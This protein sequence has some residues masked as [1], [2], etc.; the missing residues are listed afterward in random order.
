MF[1][2]AVRKKSN[3]LEKFLLKTG[4]TNFCHSQFLPEAWN[5]VTFL[6]A[7]SVTSSWGYSTECKLLY[8]QIHHVRKLNCV[9][10]VAK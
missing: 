7:P 1:P 3:N 8:S 10:K 6:S 2:K 9:A 4:K 5:L